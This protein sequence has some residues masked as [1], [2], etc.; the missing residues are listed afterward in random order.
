MGVIEV[1]RN[2]SVRLMPLEFGLIYV[3]ELCKGD[4]NVNL[5]QMT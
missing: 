1:L 5:S 4:I 2:S 3:P